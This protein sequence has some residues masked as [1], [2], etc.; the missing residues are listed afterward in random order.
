MG[1]APHGAGPGGVR[2][3]RVPLVYEATRG[4]RTQHAL[5]PEGQDRPE[6]DPDPPR[7]WGRWRRH[8]P[9]HARR[10]RRA[11]GQIGIGTILVDHPVRRPQ[12]S[13]WAST[14]CGGGSTP[15]AGTSRPPTS[16]RPGRTR[17]SRTHVPI[18]LF[19]TSVQ[20]YW[21]QAYPDE[22][23]DA[24]DVVQTV[25]FEGSTDSGCG[26]ASSQMGPFYCPNDRKVY[27]DKTFFDDMLE[28]Q[29]GAEGGP[30][31]IGYVIA[32]E[33]GHHVED[34]LGVLGKIR[35]QKGPR[36]DA[37]RVELMADCLAGVW[38]KGAQETRDQHGRAD[39]RGAEPG[40]HQARHRRRPG[41]RRRP[42]PEA[43]TSGGWT[44]T[45]SPTARPSSG[46]AGSTRGCP[47]ARSRAATPSRPT[48]CESRAAGA[49]LRYGSRRHSSTSPAPLRRARA[50]SPRGRRLP[51]RVASW[52]GRT[53]ACSAER[54]NQER[55]GQ[56]L[57]HPEIDLARW[58]GEHLS[59]EERA[60]S[61]VFTSGEHCAM[62]SA[63]HAWVGL[64]PIVYAVS[65]RQLDEW[66]SEW[67][68]AP[69]PVVTLSVNDVVPGLPV[70][71]PDPELAGGDAGAARAGV[72]QG[73]TCDGRVVTV[74]YSPVSYD[75]C[76]VGN[77]GCHVS[78]HRGHPSRS[79]PAGRTPRAGSRTRGAARGVADPDRAPVPRRAACRSCSSSPTPYG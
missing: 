42:D 53:E 20:N 44:P 29:L 54:M 70:L 26:Q 3:R 45:R 66:R 78:A 39:H 73:L 4:E 75:G 27:L 38:A 10:W 72:P 36:S 46:C 52:S 55:T 71:G 50:R 33:Y 69:S 14:S 1:T 68:A 23:G 22:T 21:K 32:H 63:A 35:T 9:A 58:A 25:R 74:Q 79:W 56:P 17:T 6:P 30:F 12:R 34:Q 28:G 18:D 60:G 47:R 7:W 40:R 2:E 24:Y 51:V 59:P 41:S 13:A 11:G 5:Q 61:T 8:A 49:N 65:S 19:T 76:A 57:A 37:V 43:F 31:A 77:N 64:G 16:A 67:G 15:A 62:C 48:T